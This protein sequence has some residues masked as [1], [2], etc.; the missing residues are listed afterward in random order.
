MLNLDLEEEKKEEEE[1]RRERGEEEEEE[2]EKDNL[3]EKTLEDRLIAE[4]A[5]EVVRREGGRDRRERA[6]LHR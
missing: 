2:M 4:L 1:G 6:T 3:V 5:A